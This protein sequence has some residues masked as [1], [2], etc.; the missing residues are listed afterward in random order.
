MEEKSGRFRKKKVNFSMVSNSI[1]RDKDISLKAKGLYALIQS[2]ITMDNFTLYKSFLMSRCCEGERAFDSAWKELKETGYLKMYKI[3]EGAK[4][5]IYEYEL[6]DVPDTGQEGQSV[7][8]QNVGVENE[9]LKDVRIQDVDGT[10]GGTFN[11]T[12][13]NNNLPNNNKSN[14]ILS[15]HISAD[16]VME[17][18]GYITFDDLD[19]RQVD[20][21]VMLMVDVLN[22]PDDQTIRIARI[23]KPVPIVK[24]RFRKLN[25]FHI[26][27][28][29]G[30]LKQ[31]TTK[32][33][34][35]QKYLLTA[36][37]NAPSTI[38]A[39]YTAEVNHDMYG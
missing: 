3:R 7:G 14:H 30:C 39:Y 33:A 21:I 20:E 4:T 32:I 31:N 11:K 22:M 10:K 13:P 19:I 38:G 24:A 18:I 36:L 5:F 25:Q 16:D 12:I 6:L 28:V 37:Y 35:I 8:V 26:Q 15:N 27:Y 9:G 29:I 23:E 2:Y 34:N 17:Q 1:I